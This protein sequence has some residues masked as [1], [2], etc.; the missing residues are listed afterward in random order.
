MIEEYKYIQGFQN[1]EEILLSDDLSHVNLY[2]VYVKDK[3]SGYEFTQTKHWKKNLILQEQY[4][5]IQKKYKG[6]QELR[7]MDEM[8]L[9]HIMP[10][11]WIGID[12]NKVS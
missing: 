5:I 9:T 7:F 1:D 6:L 2:N 10:G 3:A 8:G 12:D 11:I 4:W